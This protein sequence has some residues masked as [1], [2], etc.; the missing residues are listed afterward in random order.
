MVVGSRYQCALLLRIFPTIFLTFILVAVTGCELSISPPN[1]TLASGGDAL[2]FSSRL[3]PNADRETQRDGHQIEV[4][5]YNSSSDFN[6]GQCRNGVAGTVAQ[7]VAINALS[8]ITDILGLTSFEVSAQRPG[9]FLLRPALVNPVPALS[10]IRGGCATLSVTSPNL[11]VSNN[12]SISEFTPD[13]TKVAEIPIPFPQGGT[14]PIPWPAPF[15]ILPRVKSPTDLIV[16]DGKLVVINGIYRLFAPVNR[17]LNSYLSVYDPSNQSWNHLEHSGWGTEFE[18][19]DVPSAAAYRNYVFV[20]DSSLEQGDGRGIIRFDIT[21]G[22]SQKF[23]TDMV[24]PAS[25]LTVGLD[26]KLYVVEWLHRPLISIYHPYS[27][28]L[29]DSI[30]V[31]LPGYDPQPIISEYILDLAVNSEGQMFVLGTG[32]FVLSN[33]FYHVYR[34]SPSGQIEKVLDIPRFT[35]NDID[36]RS[37]GTLVLNYYENTGSSIKITDS[38]LSALRDFDNAVIFQSG[39]PYAAFADTVTVEGQQAPAPAPAPSPVPTS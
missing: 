25:A 20:A 35:S 17:F 39:I 26:G 22:T 1:M 29:L 31:D 6:L 3:S 7:S 24:A 38:E 11:L 14:H 15:N 36:L 4:T 28:V 2:P 13:G 33:Q 23:A 16:T 5:A 9:V 37:D 8:N 12:G 18:H 19:W 34:L 32:K 10:D 30:S 21:T 27:L